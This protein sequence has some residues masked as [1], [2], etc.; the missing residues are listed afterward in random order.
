MSF[1]T[2]V[3]FICLPCVY[4]SDLLHQN[5]RHYKGLKA[6]SSGNRPKRGSRLPGH[7]RLGAVFVWSL[8]ILLNKDVAP[9]SG[10]SH[11]AQ[12]L[13]SLHK[14]GYSWGVMGGESPSLGRTKPNLSAPPTQGSCFVWSCVQRKPVLKCLRMEA[15]LGLWCCFSFFFI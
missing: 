13:L 8:T 6:A 5:Q 4:L 3:I 2:G 12:C 7:L 14:H 9:Y 10:C 11:P 15:M 1:S